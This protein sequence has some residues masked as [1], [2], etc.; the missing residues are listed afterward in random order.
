MRNVEMYLV[1]FL[2]FCVEYLCVPAYGFMQK[3]SV[4]NVGY[5]KKYRNYINFAILT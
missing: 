5:R 2:A 1:A 4:K 3:T